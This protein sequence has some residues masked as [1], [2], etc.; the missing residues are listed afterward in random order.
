MP[1]GALL[2]LAA[3]S[4]SNY[5]AHKNQKSW[6]HLHKISSLNSLPKWQAV[7]QSLEQGNAAQRKSSRR[8]VL[9]LIKRLP[10]VATSAAASGPVAGAG[11]G[12]VSD[13]LLVWIQLIVTIFQRQRHVLHAASWSLLRIRI[14]LS[15]I[16]FSSWHAQRQSPEHMS[17]V[18]AN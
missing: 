3:H 6:K 11:S 4:K 13:L 1:G 14:A 17:A 12:P 9:K 7:S 8:R 15:W 5:V 18:K 10:S 2:L 16:S